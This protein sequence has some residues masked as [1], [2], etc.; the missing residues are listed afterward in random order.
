VP[1]GHD[2]RAIREVGLDLLRSEDVTEPVAETAT[3]WRAARAQR[4]SDL[5]WLEGEPRFQGQQR[6]LEVTATL[7]RE[8]RLSRWLFLATRS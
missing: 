4:A 7:A 6:F 1:Q 3:R 5:G 8:R 2:E